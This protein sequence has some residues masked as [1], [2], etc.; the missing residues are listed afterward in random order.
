MEST[1]GYI[2]TPCVG[3]F[4]SPGITKTPDRRDQRMLVSHPKDIEIHNL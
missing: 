1:T 3:S 2:F 4:T